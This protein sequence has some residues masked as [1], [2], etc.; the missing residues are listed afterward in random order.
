MID[1]PLNE[2]LIAAI[3]SLPVIIGVAV[4]I[5]A[6]LDEFHFHH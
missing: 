6:Y 3:F 2:T 4:M 5:W 1:T